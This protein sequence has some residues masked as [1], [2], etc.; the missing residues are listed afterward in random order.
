MSGCVNSAASIPEGRVPALLSLCRKHSP[1]SWASPGCWQPVRIFAPQKQKGA[2][3]QAVAC[4]T[5][6]PDGC[7]NWRVPTLGRP[8]ASIKSCICSISRWSCSHSPSCLQCCSKDS[9]R[10]VAMTSQL[11]LICV[12]AHPDN[13]SLG[14][15]QKGAAV[16]Q[17]KEPE[18]AMVD[19]QRLACEEC[20]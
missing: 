10:E 20:N 17:F 8:C 13:E 2:G 5:G 12:L 16:M 14:N 11:K 3:L 19:G 1:R 4:S 18:I 7:I 9:T 15:S 6:T